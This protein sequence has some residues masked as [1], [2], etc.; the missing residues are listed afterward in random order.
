MNETDVV[1]DDLQT[2]LDAKI[3][4][5]AVGFTLLGPRSI[6]VPPIE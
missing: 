3:A 1:L 2:L 5:S 4:G 6:V